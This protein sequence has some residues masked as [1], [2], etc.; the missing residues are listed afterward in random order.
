[1]L[2]VPPPAAP[3]LR[4]A[5]LLDVGI[6]ARSAFGLLAVHPFAAV[7]LRP[8]QGVEHEWGDD[9]QQTEHEGDAADHPRKTST[10]SLAP[11]VVS[12]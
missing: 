6:P 1:M 9:G 11:E 5:G 8:D 4:R 10:M 7:V 2:R 12:R 3:T